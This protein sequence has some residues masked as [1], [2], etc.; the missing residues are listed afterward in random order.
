MGRYFI[1]PQ[2]YYNSGGEKMKTKE[3]SLL[4]KEDFHTRNDLP[5]W[6]YKE[7]QTFHQ[8]VTDKTFPCF[9][10]MRGELKGE[11][12][13]AYVTQD[14]WSNL[15]SAL[16]NFLKLFQEPDA[17]RHGLFVFVEPLDTEGQLD[18]YRKQFWEILQYLHN[19]DEV[20][21]PEDSPRDPD[22]YLWDFHFH[23]EPIFVFG[24]AP[25]YKKRKTRDLGNA[26]VLGFQP[27]RIFKGLEGTE[28]TGV[29]S[30]EQVRK[31]VE[32][33]DQLPKHPDIGHYGDPTHHEWKQF[34]IGD[35]IEPIKGKCPFH[36]KEQ[37]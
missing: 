3:Q 16:I 23:G 31:R 12:R 30:R 8:T 10:G 7:Y 15:P 11:L 9:F 6:L 35:D 18:D 14:D 2:I 36:H 32:M 27:R 4:T 29:M 26:M 22:H 13:Y 1:T 24:N 34:F 19:V 20:S 33:W 17:K 25:A 37:E 21:W 5:E 28:R